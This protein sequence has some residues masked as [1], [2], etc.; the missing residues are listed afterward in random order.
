MI[1]TGSMLK[2]FSRYGEV[3]DCVVMKN[4]ATGK[5]RGFGFVTFKDPACVEMVLSSGPHVLDDRQVRSSVSNIIHPQ[6]LHLFHKHCTGE[7]VSSG[8]P[9]M[10]WR[11]LLE[12]RFTTCMPLLTAAST[13]HPGEDLELFSLMLLFLYR[14][15]TSILSFTG[16]QLQKVA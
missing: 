5:S 11:I 9:V 4:P 16:S 13:L 12:H 3:I 1:V 10:N 6:H 7:P 14:L 8:N 2:Y 15:R